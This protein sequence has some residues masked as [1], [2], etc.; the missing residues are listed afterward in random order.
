MLAKSIQPSNVDAQKKQKIQLL[1]DE[2]YPPY[3]YIE[4]GVLKGKTVDVIR[5]IDKHLDGYDIELVPVKWTR[6]LQRVREGEALGI[7]GVYFSGRHRP[8][9]YPYSSPLV[10]DEAVIVCNSRAK[11]NRPVVWPE[12][13][14]DNIVLNIAG[15][16]GWL[17]FK[18]RD[19]ANTAHVNFLEVPDHAT[20]FKMLKLGNAHCAF[21]EQTLATT[22]L[23]PQNDNELALQV[24]KQVSTQFIR[25]GYSTKYWQEHAPSSTLKFAKAFDF[26]LQNLREEG[27]LPE[28]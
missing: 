21:A 11:I 19:A 8:Y 2:N 20:V 23:A 4:S 27:H 18:T 16:D 28:L 17:N 14:E 10:K 13:F 12:S 3:S 7:V 9:L 15:F 6:G 5:A 24:V 1:T 22:H 25:I 26:A